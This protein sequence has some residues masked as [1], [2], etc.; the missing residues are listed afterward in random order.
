[1]DRFVMGP[2]VLHLDNSRFF[3]IMIT[4]ITRMRNIAGQRITFADPL[5][6]AFYQEVK[7]T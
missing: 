7:S 3:D 6:S 5:G 2:C 4:M 1:M